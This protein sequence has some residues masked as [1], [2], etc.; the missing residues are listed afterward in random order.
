MRSSRCL[1]RA[2][3]RWLVLVVFALCSRGSGSRC[4]RWRRSN[5]ADA[6]DGGE[7]VQELVHGHGG[8]VRRR[9]VSASAFG[10]APGRSSAASAW[11]SRRGCYRLDVARVDEVRILVAGVVA[12]V[13]HE[14]FRTLKGALL[15]A[16]D[17][18]PG[19]FARSD[20]LFHPVAVGRLAIGSEA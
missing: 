6:Q 15:A 16:L 2:C 20:S 8:R 1:V 17:A 3:G 7:S 14:R 13:M 4:A 9:A 18:S 11:S 5:P 12:S 10:P 19:T